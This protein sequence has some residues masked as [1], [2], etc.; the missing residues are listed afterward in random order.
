MN[1]MKKI[2]VAGLVVSAAFLSNA[3]LVARWDFNNFDPENP[4]STNILAATVGGNG[5][6]C[7][8][9]SLESPSVLTNDGTIGAMYVVSPDYS[10]SDTCVTNAAAKLG[11][12]NYAIAIPKYSHVALPIPDVVK[13]HVWTLKMRI[14]VPGTGGWRSFF[15]RE[16]TT[17]GDSFLRACQDY[18][19]LGGGR[20]KVTGT[21]NNYMTTVTVGE[22]HT[23]TFS[24]GEQYWDIFVDETIPSNFNRSSMFK[25]YFNDSEPLTDIDGVGHLLL[26]G[27][28]NGEDGLMYIDYVELYDEASVYEG[29][30]AQYTKA[31]LTGEWTFPEGEV[32]KANIGLDLVKSTREGEADFT[33]GSDGVLPG[34]G[35]VRA[36]QNNYFLCYHGLPSNS[37]YSVVM[38]VRV[39]DNDHA[40]K[41]YHA[42]FKTTNGADARVFFKWE[43][44]VLNFRATGAKTIPIDADIG[45][46]V[47]V[48]ITY[49]SRGAVKSMYCNG[50][51]KYS[52]PDTYLAP[53]K[54]G[55]F[56]LLGD[57]NGED[58]DVDISYAAVYDR[59][60]TAEDIAEIHA[61]PLAQDADGA[62][63]LTAAPAGVW[64]DDGNGGL[65]T[66]RGMPLV[67]GED[68]YS[69][70]RTAAPTSATYVADITLASEQTGRGIF[71]INTNG[72]ASG[73]YG[74]TSTYSGSFN[75][76]T[77]ADIFTGDTSDSTWGDWSED[78]LDRTSAHRVAVTWAGN[79][80][81]HYYV[82]GRPWGQQAPASTN[83][84]AS[85]TATMRFFDGLGATVTR[86]VAY[87]VPLTTDEI[88]TLGTVATQPSG[89][90][91]VVTLDPVELSRG[92]AKVMVDTISFNVSAT[93]SDGEYVSFFIDYGD[94]DSESQ[95]QFSA[96]GTA[97]AF[98]HMYMVPGTYT[99]RVSAI[100]QS[101]VSSETV[102]TSLQALVA[103]PG[104][105]V[106]FH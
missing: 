56:I 5:R 31:A 77:N 50:E 29:K 38:D 97:V 79:G 93:Q 17:D 89:S 52:G 81:V 45:E 55:Y 43:N 21:N 9:E 35:H 91:P 86:L 18:F 82:D 23:I 63:M 74:T 1:R 26:C 85:P 28:E 22:W 46:W 59:A 99:V 73:I 32:T 98:S 92:Y 69:W 14:L 20:F 62:F 19:E 103:W 64:V 36:G 47:R 76:S 25:S 16:N 57:D 54:G 24:V 58:Y 51:L 67:A 83:N 30:L 44:G 60:L 7:F 102:T 95:V 6:P 34:D 78:A 15:N 4:T 106:I 8:F 39:P 94:G 61:R 90:A 101:G 13:G 72:V 71:A 96:P 68:G 70:T 40:N 37:N 105:T 65:E 27:D 3:E 80:L 33:E 41:T 66:E 42:L 12:G 75:T 53:N 104:M 48:V 2:M 87:D 10:G 11:E 49:Q 88:A 84:A 100:S